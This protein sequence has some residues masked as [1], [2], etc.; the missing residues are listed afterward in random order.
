MNLLLSKACFVLKWNATPTGNWVA[1]RKRYTP[2]MTN[3]TRETTKYNSFCRLVITHLFSYQNDIKYLLHEEF[4]GRSMHIAHETKSLLS[5]ITTAQST[6]Q[7]KRIDRSNSHY[8]C[9]III[10]EQ[11]EISIVKWDTKRKDI[12]NI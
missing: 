10:T 9:L 2:R 4:R 11:R 1:W 5:W 8:Y 12:V 3:G 7:A 6:I